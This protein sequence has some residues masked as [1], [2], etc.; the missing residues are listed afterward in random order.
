M[1]SER[2]PGIE[3]PPCRR[4][5]GPHYLPRRP[6]PIH[7]LLGRTTGGVILVHL[8]ATTPPKTTGRAGHWLPVLLQL[9]GLDAMADDLGASPRSLRSRFLRFSTFNV[10][11]PR[12]HV[13]SHSPPGWE[14]ITMRKQKISA[15]HRSPF[16]SSTVPF[17]ERKGSPAVDYVLRQLLLTD[18]QHGRGLFVGRVDLK[19]QGEGLVGARY[20]HQLG[21][22]P[23]MVRTR[24]PVLTSTTAV[25]M[26]VGA[27]RFGYWSPT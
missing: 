12:T 11:V 13:C 6:V 1:I 14:P 15:G 21:R 7:T 24:A 22:N 5:E 4:W 10:A 2:L 26:R 20:P 17:E 9:I 3:G 19:G 18:L 23:G 16:R 25:S 8:A 27:G